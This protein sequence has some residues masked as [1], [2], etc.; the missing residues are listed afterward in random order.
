[1]CIFKRIIK[2]LCV[3]I[4]FTCGFS[5]NESSQIEDALQIHTSWL[6]PKSKNPYTLKLKV[7]GPTGTR[8][9]VLGMSGIIYPSQQN[10]VTLSIPLRKIGT[11]T[12]IP[13]Q[14]KYKK[15]QFTLQ[16]DVPAG[17]SLQK[18]VELVGSGYGIKNMTLSSS[19]SANP[20]KPID[21]LLRH[22][23]ARSNFR[24]VAAVWQCD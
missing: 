4:F 19:L 13:L 24:G 1:M 7:D 16:V 8:V 11:H 5:C 23:P 14:A 21:P 9:K 17:E 3:L 6:T 18:T 20:S 15:Q 12:Q 2:K 22:F 10:S